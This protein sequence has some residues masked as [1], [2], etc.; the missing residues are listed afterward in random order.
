MNE[1]IR[2]N[3]LFRTLWQR[4]WIILIVTAV[5]SVSFASVSYFNK[6]TFYE[7]NAFLRIDGD[8][9]PA[10]TVT[11]INGIKNDLTI[12]RIK[13]A[14]GLDMTISEISNSLSI[15][16]T[17]DSSAFELK[18]ISADP[19]LA[20]KIVNQFTYE[21]AVKVEITERSNLIS[22][23]NKRLFELKQE[24][25]LS[26]T[27]IM[28]LENEI[29]SIDP[30]ISITK[31]LDDGLLL[32][33]RSTLGNTIQ[34]EEINPVYEALA[35]KYYTAKITNQKLM[36]EKKTIDSTIND[37]KAIIA[38]LENSLILNEQSKVKA[39]RYFDGLSV[40]TISPA[41]EVKELDS[42][43]TLLKAAISFIVTMIICCFI[44]LI[45]AYWL[46]ESTV[47]NKQKITS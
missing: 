14:L 5:I 1:V 40:V 23:K 18:Y 3:D 29:K 47:G 38:K 15:T 10:E 32:S 42:Q 39:S 36:M 9:E 17:N 16:Q 35:D 21:Y 30:K 20:L 2:M 26:E 8:F 24:L 27:E 6:M 22:Q 45:K 46:T 31:S 34:T 19:Q 33:N 41:V 4:K 25:P 28:T 12:N 11:L 43:G 7:S 13:K 37:Q 44:I